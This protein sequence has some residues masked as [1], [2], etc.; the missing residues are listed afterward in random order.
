MKINVCLKC[1]KE[2][3]K[4]TFSPWDARAEYRTFDFYCENCMHLRQIIDV[5]LPCSTQGCGYSLFLSHL[6]LV[7]LDD[8]LSA[9]EVEIL[10]EHLKISQTCPKCHCPGTIGG[11]YIPLL[12]T[13]EAGEGR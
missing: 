7:D 9:L 10:L 4:D 13:S 1:K 6:N 5:K 8:K 2:L 3:S 11:Y 12:E